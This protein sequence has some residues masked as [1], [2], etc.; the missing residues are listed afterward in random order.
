MTNMEVML[1]IM[2][3]LFPVT[4]WLLDKYWRS[5]KQTEYIK[6]AVMLWPGHF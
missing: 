4:D 6:T 2:L 3:A 1:L 5:T